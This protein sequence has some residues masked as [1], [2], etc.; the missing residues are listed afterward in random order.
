MLFQALAFSCIPFVSES[1]LPFDQAL[2]PEI[3][4]SADETQFSEE[5][6][7]HLPLHTNIVS[8][9]SDHLARNL[10]VLHITLLSVF[11]S[12]STMSSSDLQRNEVLALVEAHFAEK[13]HSLKRASEVVENMFDAT[14][15]SG[16]LTFEHIVVMVA[17]LEQVS[18]R[19]QPFLFQSPLQPCSLCACLLD[20]EAVLN[21]R[22]WK[23]A[24]AKCNSSYESGQHADRDVAQTHMVDTQ[25]TNSR[26]AVAGTIAKLGVFVPAVWTLIQMAAT[27]RS[28]LH[29]KSD[30]E[31]EPIHQCFS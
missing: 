27:A 8:E 29:G 5:P 31:P 9:S 23:A 17:R 1:C 14:C 30:D 2:D 21:S 16:E 15:G 28:R 10:L 7:I 22:Q 3:G 13:H 12:I 24:N 26:R 25:S 6:L 20:D 11:Q 18:R 19:G 4:F